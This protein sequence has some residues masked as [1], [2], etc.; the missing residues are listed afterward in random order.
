MIKHII[1]VLLVSILFVSCVKTAGVNDFSDEKI[2]VEV[3]DSNNEDS[4]VVP[5][6]PTED[7]IY[8]EY[9]VLTDDEEI[10][11]S[12]KK[13]LYQDVRYPEIKMN[14]EFKNSETGQKI[15]GSID[16]LNKT[17]NNEAIDF[18][19]ENE[20]DVRLVFK[21][22]GDEGANYQY[23]NELYIERFDDKILSITSNCYE[24]RMGAHGSTTI[25]GFNIDIETGKIIRFDKL[26]SD[27]Q[28]IKE[29]IMSFLNENYK[30]DLMEYYEDTIDSYL[31][32]ETELSY[33]ITVEGINIVFQQYDL[34]PYAVGIITVPVNYEKNKELFNKN[35]WQ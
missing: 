22:R 1:A 34:A 11:G 14:S 16:L 31:Q 23:L 4:P 7:K 8:I 21:E 30:D 32:G 12:D 18:L 20:E 33:N 26:I 19:N 3:T 5:N 6:L 13:I 25:T 9:N 28:K 15:S 29:L 24:D 27:K 10:E 2:E 17:F 35:Y